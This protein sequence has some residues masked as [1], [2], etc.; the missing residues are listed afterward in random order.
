MVLL[1]IPG[2]FQLIDVL[3]VDADVGVTVP[4]IRDPRRLDGLP[5]AFEDALY[6]LVFAPRGLGGQHGCDI[7]EVTEVVLD[8]VVNLHR[9]QFLTEQFAEQLSHLTGLVVVLTCE[10]ALRIGI[11][12][13]ASAGEV[14]I[15]GD[16]D[17]LRQAD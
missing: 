15:G 1:I 10:T 4:V 8:D 14:L 12:N 2:A 3:V 17:V 7:T 13:D 11:G 16:V 6:A 9:A 5:Q